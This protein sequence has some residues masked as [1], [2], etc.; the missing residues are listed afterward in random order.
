MAANSSTTQ[1]L[2]F[3]FAFYAQYDDL[4]KN[5]IIMI[6]LYQLSFILMLVSLAHETPF[7]ASLTDSYQPHKFRTESLLWLLTALKFHN[8]LKVK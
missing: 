1:E 5:K 2:I 7:S 4:K 3:L 8:S 6:I